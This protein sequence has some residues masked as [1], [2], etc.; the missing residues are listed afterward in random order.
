MIRG[1][2]MEKKT[3]TQKSAGFDPKNKNKILKRAKSYDL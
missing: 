2:K 3:T 1:G